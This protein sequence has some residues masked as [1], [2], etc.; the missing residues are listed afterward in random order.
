MYK[1]IFDKK[2][3][4]KI[5]RLDRITKKRVWGKLQECKKNPQKY[6]KQL[7]GIKLFKLRI[8][9]YRIIIDLK[10]ELR[11]LNVLDIGNRKNIYK[12]L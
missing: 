10:K 4:K 8:G 6:L 2:A 1:L 5:N 7:T 9:Q 11:I 12:N 3:L